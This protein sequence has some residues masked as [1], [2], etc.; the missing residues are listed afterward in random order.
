M[1][2]R[3]LD[4]FSG[5]YSAGFKFHDENLLMLSWYAERMIKALRQRGTRSLISLGIGHGVVPRAVI[6]ALGGQLD[7]YTVVE[8]SP[9]SVEEF[10]ASERLPATLELANALF[11]EFEA[12]TPVDAVE[13]GFVLE[14]VE[15]PGPVVRRFAGFLRPAGAMVIVVPNALSLHRRLGNQAGL[16]EDMYG[17]SAHDLQLGH[18]RYFDRASLEG[19][20]EAA[21]LRVLKTEGIFLKC[22][23]TDQLHRLSLP[24]AVVR[25][26][27]SV[28]VDYPEL[29]NAIYVE[30]S[31]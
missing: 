22:L 6:G 14:H 29:C 31:R 27:F 1:D 7:R 9:R 3:A 26:L 30:A 21:G 5:A 12:A 15:D 17:L 18:R 24:P 11:E 23:T 20:V 16:L 10:R 28:G 19:L 25:A 4:G 2:K 8:G 13:L